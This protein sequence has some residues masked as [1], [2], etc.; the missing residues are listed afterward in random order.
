MNRFSLL[1]FRCPPL[2]FAVG[3][4][5]AL[6]APAAHPAGTGPEQ[7]GAAIASAHPLATAAGHEILGRGGNAFDAAVAVAAV[8]AVVE[9][10]ASGLGGG[11]LWLLHRASDGRQVMVDAR[12][13]APAGVKPE[14]YVDGSGNPVRGATRRGG[15]AAAIPGAP[16]ALVHVAGHY[17]TLPLAESLAPA[18]RHARGGVAVGERYA[19]LAELREGMLREYAEASRIF[20]D[21]GRAPQAGWRLRQTDL[22][23]TLERLAR[24]GMEGFYGGPVARALVDSVNE[25]GGVWQVRDLGRYRVVERAPLRFT[26]RGAFITTAT[27][28]SAGG[29]A[30]AQSLQ[31]LERFD[32]VDTRTPPGAHL[33]VETLRRAFRDR[34]AYL[35]DADFVTV[36][37]ERLTSRTYAEGMAATINPKSAT[38]SEVPEREPK[39]A[40]SAN[41]T[42][43]SVVDAAG[44]RVAATLTIN[45]IFGAGVVA[46]GTGVLLNNE[47]DDFTVG[48]HV[49]NTFRL[50]GGEANAIAPGKRPLSS[51]TPTFV[52]DAKGV[53]VLGTPGGSRI[54]SQVL[55][56]VLDY[57]RA[58]AV[59]LAAIVVAPR[60]HH[61]WWPDEVELEPGAFSAQWRAALEA[62]GH[63]LQPA[64]RPWG[65]MQAVFKSKRDGRAVAA[66]DP[67]GADY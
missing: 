10:F 41:T 7:A 34:A 2:A 30:L 27:L 3:A 32:A 26:Y 22:A 25:A 6:A 66:S 15:T 42:H 45:L 23:A 67:R 46:R 40:E 44:N 58:P 64:R 33:V 18:I 24:D 49:P 35:G 48:P 14:L 61:Q 54:V 56:A 5:L 39:A 50:R 47:M 65:N 1:V 63:R 36:P 62:R 29:I 21:G 28:P 37:L 11:G 9:P 53:L 57:V 20:L 55:L 60:Y 16:A 8:L 51:M 19:R 31:M 4:L 43:L 12:E 52:E 13:T 38:R 59:D 17:G